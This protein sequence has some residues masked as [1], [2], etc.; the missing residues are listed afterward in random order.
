[1]ND[2]TVFEDG[3]DQVNGSM[4]G[5]KMNRRVFQHNDIRLFA[6]LNAADS[7]G[8]VHRGRTVDGEGGD[9]LFNRQAHVNAG[10][11]NHQGNGVGK[12]AAGVQVAA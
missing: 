12:A 6:G 11:C 1:M 7:V 3:F 2:L 9:G 5:Q 4:V 8:S 10:E